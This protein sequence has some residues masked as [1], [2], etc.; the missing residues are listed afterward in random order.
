MLINN[1][2]LNINF[3]KPKESNKDTTIIF[4]HGMAEYSKSYEEVA[5]FF[6]NKGFHVITYDV[7]GHGKSEG[8]RGYVKSY[9]DFVNDLKEIVNLAYKETKNVFLAGHSMGGLITNLYASIY[10]N[11]KGVINTA[12]PTEY[13]KN[14]KK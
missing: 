2:N 3:Y 8:K 4:T 13:S 9:M 1:V 7:R 11:V 14:L 12:T 6:Q 5:L 10:N